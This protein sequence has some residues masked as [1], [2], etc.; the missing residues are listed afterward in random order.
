[1]TRAATS[2]TSLQQLERWFLHAPLRFLG[3]GVALWI[4]WAVAAT[5]LASLFRVER[6]VVPVLGQTAPA[7]EAVD[8]LFVAPLLEN[9]LLWL[10]FQAARFCAAQWWPAHAGAL[11]VALGASAF[12]LGHWPFKTLFGIEVL[13]G[14]WLMSMCFLWGARHRAVARGLVLSVAAHLGVNGVAFA[15]FHA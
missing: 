8:V 5:V 4:V 1:M 15:L 12:A 7:R 6:A 3:A 13:A 10:V 2:E 11:A 9:A 14:G